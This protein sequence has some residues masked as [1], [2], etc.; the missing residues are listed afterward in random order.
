MT[1]PLVTL[2]L[3]CTKSQREL[4]TKIAERSGVPVE[5]FVLAAALEHAYQVLDDIAAH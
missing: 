1:G 5:E 2:E 4:L 3:R